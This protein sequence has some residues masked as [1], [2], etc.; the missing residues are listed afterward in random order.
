MIRAKDPYRDIR[1]L[2]EAWLSLHR[3]VG[4]LLE[5]DS[6]EL[7]A[8]IENELLRIHARLERLGVRSG[9]PEAQDAQV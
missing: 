7:R 5:A 8:R 2:R 9:H 6:P 1:A 4:A 3:A